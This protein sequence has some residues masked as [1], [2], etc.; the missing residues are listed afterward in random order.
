MRRALAAVLIGLV[1][2]AV[3]TYAYVRL[4]LG[5]D[6]VR[7]ALEQ[8]LSIRLGQPVRIGAAGASLF[9]RVAI[10]LSD[11]SVGSPAAIQLSSVH[12][13][14]GLRGLLSRTIDEAEVVASG[15]RVALPLPFPLVPAASSSG[16]P[17]S[18]SGITVVSVRTIALR[19]IVLTGSN[20]TL[21]VDLESS[22]AGDRLEIGELQATADRTRIR[23][24]GVVNSLAALDARLDATASPLDLNEVIA[25]I[26]AF[27]GPAAAESPGAR[28]PAIPMHLS[29]A[30]K[31]PAGRLATYDFEDLSSTVDLTGERL[32]LDPLDLR[33]LGGRFN[34][35]LQA[36]LQGDVPRLR[37]TGQ[38]S[39][40]DVVNVLKAS[41]SPGG[42]T[43][44]LGGTVSLA[45]EGT[46][47]EALLKTAR[48][49]LSA[50]VTNG[51][52]PHLDLV[53]TI[54]LAFGKPSGA[55]P[56][57]SGSAFSR[58]GGTFALAGG[59]LTSTDLAMASRD[60]DMKGSGSLRISTAAV[61]ARADVVLSSELTSQ[62]GTDLR[63]FAQEDGRVIVPSRVTGT[64]QQPS[65]TVDVVAATKR[66]LNNELKRRANTFMEGLFKKR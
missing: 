10:D 2:I 23:A 5:A 33:T 14:V 60:F 35:R 6:P 16:A 19:D 3:G 45:G 17:A 66:A 58:L 50:A 56:E 31:A 8:Q 32:V 62:A 61:D 38:V 57:G 46:D 13:A 39:G 48:G 54:V 47:P 34:G 64:L 52:L 22:L 29:M 25:I 43:G 51:S 37:M 36:D 53:R 24:T 28:A 55:P 1:V 44:T 42:V 65:V 20:R 41:N 11:V 9:P 26:S 15:G 59:T 49:T 12:I 30:L 21:R 27:T 40:L 4:T 18:S 63:R 7:T